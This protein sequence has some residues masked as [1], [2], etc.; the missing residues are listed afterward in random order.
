MTQNRIGLLATSFTVLHRLEDNLATAQLPQHKGP[1]LP[2]ED[3][4]LTKRESC[5]RWLPYALLR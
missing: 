5:G 1:S 4:R 3:K 2:E